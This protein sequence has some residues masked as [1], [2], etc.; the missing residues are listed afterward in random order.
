MTGLELD[1]DLHTHSSTSDG[2]A[3]VAEMIEAAERA[4]LRQIALTD[5]VRASTTWVPDYV[6][7][8]SRERRG[9]S[10]EVIC[11]VEAKILDTR[12]ALD[13]PAD[14]R[15]IAQVVVADHQFPTRRGPVSPQEVALLVTSGRVR[16]EDAVADL[17][18]ATARAVFRHERVVVGHLFSV[19]P[20]AGL[21]LHLVTLEMLETLAAACRD[22][23]A[24][25]EVNEKWRTPSQDVVRVLCSLG[26]EIVASSDAHA[27][28]AVGVWSHVA[29]VAADARVG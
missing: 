10:V 8:V 27:P 6:R 24:A 17:L 15:G 21:G 11:G 12:G 13:V 23:G 25:V 19:L 4:G 20:K 7:E 18:D 14:L 9:R 29:D 3:P 1:R 28:A 22:A 26:V 5:H 16:A 2:A